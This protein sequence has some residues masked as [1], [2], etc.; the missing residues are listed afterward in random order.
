M[1]SILILSNLFPSEA[2]PWGGSFISARAES[3]ARAGHDVRVLALVPCRPLILRLALRLFRKPSRA[4]GAVSEAPFETLEIPLGPV[5]YIRAW[6][7]AYPKRAV[8]RAAR[9]VFSRTHG[10]DFEVVIGHGM[11]MIP[12][13]SVAKAVAS[14]GSYTVV[15][16]G[17]DINL[18]M[19]RRARAYSETFGNARRVIF[20][21]SA[22]VQRARDL[23]METESAV[24][25]PNGVDL[26]R[27]HPDRR[28]GARTRLGLSDSPIVAFLGALAKVKGADRIPCIARHLQR[29][30]PDARILVGGEGP[31]GPELRLTS[32]PNVEYLGH[33]DRDQAADLLAAADVLVLPSRNEGWPTVILEAFACGTHV[34]GTAVGGIPEALG[35]RGVVVSSG[36]DVERRLGAALSDVLLCRDDEKTRELRSFAAAYSWDAIALAELEAALP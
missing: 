6:R 34:V 29:R 21:S 4:H 3:L 9:I 35:K 30:C 8:A 33:L 12:A 1:T 13:G 31:L 7:G 22:L 28:A 5:E 24:V 11:F 18:L 17:S 10:T 27:F 16:H 15:C 19:E 26:D 36:E 32:P 2:A 20:V 14:T 23:G 25:I